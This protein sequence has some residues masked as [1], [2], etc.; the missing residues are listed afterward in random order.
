MYNA[1]VKTIQ[2]RQQRYDTLG[3]YFTEGGV[4][5]FRVSSMGNADYEFLIWVHEAIE[6]Q[7]ARKVG[8]TE[9]MID[10]W[11]LAHEDVEEPGEMVECP[12][13]NCHMVAEAI[14]RVVAE[15]LGVDWNHYAKT[16][17]EVLAKHL[18][19]ADPTLRDQEAMNPEPTLLVP[20]KERHRNPGRT[21]HSKGK[22][23]ARSILKDRET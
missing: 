22:V 14:E 8:I 6:K 10:A 19:P 20:R 16:C 18:P 15:K 12:Y 1:N 13:H 23:K 11:D 21:V 3:D 2:H 4:I 17:S 7:L 9:Q 5:Q